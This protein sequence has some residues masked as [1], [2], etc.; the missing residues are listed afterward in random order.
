MVDV[1]AG[2]RRRRR[3]RRRRRSVR[4]RRRAATCRPAGRPRRPAVGHDRPLPAARAGARAPARTGSTARRRCGPGR[5]ARRIDALR[6]ARRRRSRSGEPGHLPGRP[7]GGAGRGAARSRCRATCRASSCRSAAGRRRRARRARRSSSTTPLVS[8]PY[9]EHDGRGD[10]G[11]RRR[12]RRRRRRCVVPTGG[13]RAADLRRRA[14]RHRPRRTSSPPPPS[15][16]GG[17]GST[18]SGGGSLQGDLAL[19]RRA[20]PHGRR[21]RRAATTRTDGA[22]ARGALHGRRRRPGRPVRHRPDAR[23]RGRR[24]PTRPTRVTGHRLHPGARRPTGSAARGRRAAAVRHRRRGGAP[25]ASSSTRARP[26]P[27]VVETY[28]DHRMAMSFALLGLRVPGHRDRRPGLRGQD[29]PRLL[30]RA[31]RACGAAGR[32]RPDAGDRH[33]RAGRLGQVDRRPAAGRAARPRRTSTPAPCTGRRLRRPAP[34]RSTPTD[35]EAVA[36]MVA[37]RSSSTSSDGDGRR[38][39]AST[40]PSRSAG[41]E[42]TRAVSTVAANPGGAGRAAAPPAGV[43]AEPHGGGVVEGRD[44]GT[45]VFPDAELKVY[46][47]ARAEVRAGRRHKEVADLDY[48]TVAADMARRDTRRRASG[49]T[50]RCRSADDAV[51]ID[52]TDRIGRRDR[53]RARSRPT[54]VT[55]ADGAAPAGAAARLRRSGV[56]YR[57]VRAAGRRLLPGRSGGSTVAGHRERPRDGPFILAPGAPRRTST[58]RWCAAV[59]RRP[60]RYMGKDSLWKYR[61]VGWFFTALGRLPGAPGRGRPGG[62]APVRRRPRRRRAAGDVPRGHPPAGPMVEDAVRRRRLRRRRA[63]VRRSCRSASAGPSGPCRK[64]AKCIR[65]VE[66][67]HRRRRADRTRRRRRAAAGC[68]AGPCG[69]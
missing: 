12:G 51:V 49:T 20:R 16:A 21:R 56:S 34:G 1:P 65:P 66:A 46:L 5:W 44:I 32:V 30:G 64:G 19:R 35:A 68:P 24:S 17:C 4:R 27:A 38:S 45:V 7:C 52:T 61:L 22:P 54:A 9:V 26:R 63:R 33:R 69:S 14:R 50:T 10:G 6:G 18:G 59:T 8:R 43:G 2:A 25:T 42:V 28:D 47:T 48:E 40:P 37:R 23:R 58:R 67:A 3:R 29:V 36:R 11:V 57:V 41:P 15:P 13:Y 53:R 39:T 62:A 55:R 60:L 31:R